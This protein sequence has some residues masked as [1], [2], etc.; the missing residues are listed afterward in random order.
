MAVCI[1]IY[2]Y[3]F[4]FKSIPK[5]PPLPS[6]GR[7]QAVRDFVGDIYC[8]DVQCQPHQRLYSRLGAHPGHPRR[9]AGPHS[10]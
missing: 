8:G 4:F 7:Y 1:F 9:H 5:S 6:A 10:W 3:I 2:I